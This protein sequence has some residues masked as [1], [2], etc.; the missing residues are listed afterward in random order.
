[1]FA[2]AFKGEE[3]YLYM[4]HHYMSR[5]RKVAQQRRIADY[6][7]GKLEA[8]AQDI[9]GGLD[10]NDWIDAWDRQLEEQ[11]AEEDDP[12]AVLDEL[13]DATPP[14]ESDAAAD[15]AEGEVEEDLFPEETDSEDDDDDDD[16]D[17]D[18]DGEEDEPSSSSSEEEEED[19]E[20]EE[21]REKELQ[22]HVQVGGKGSF[23]PVTM[24]LDGEI[25]RLIQ[26]KEGLGAGVVVKEWSPKI[27]ACVVGAP[28]KLR[29]SKGKNAAPTAHQLRLDLASGV[30]DEHKQC[31]YIICVDSAS[32]CEEWKAMLEP[33]HTSEYKL[34]SVEQHHLKQKKAPKIV[35]L[36]VN[37]SGMAL[38]DP[39]TNK[40]YE[41][42]RFIKVRGWKSDA[43]KLYLRVMYDP[44]HHSLPDDTTSFWLGTARGQEVCDLMKSIALAVAATKKRDKWRADAIAANLP[45]QIEV[46]RCQFGG[47]GKFEPVTMELAGDRFTMETHLGAIT[48]LTNAKKISQATVSTP[49][50]VRRLTSTISVPTICDTMPCSMYP[51]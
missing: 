7:A 26:Y 9:F 10:G 27:T 41:R 38:M 46:G 11:A 32:V 39:T 47:K 21:K 35:S 42:Y 5:K 33:A 50:K 17:G 45:N 1:M 28:K 43:S 29:P 20:E 36:G 31:K 24:R 40:V 2:E 37:R 15:A 13:F 25:L 16:D 30:V 34:F 22:A 4:R 49:K 18:G 48:R 14:S 51:S 6:R 19:I 12:L 44:E 8:V 3:Y 23:L